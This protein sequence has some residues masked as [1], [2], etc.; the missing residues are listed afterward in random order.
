MGD[1]FPREDE[2]IAKGESD[3]TN[4][5]QMMVSFRLLAS[6]THNMAWGGKLLQQGAVENKILPQSTVKTGQSAFKA[7]GKEM[8]QYQ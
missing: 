8:R 3:Y 1:Y 4:V 7:G 5:M 2:S 6:K